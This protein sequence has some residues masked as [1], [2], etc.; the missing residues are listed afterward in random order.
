HIEPKSR[1]GLLTEDNTQALCRKCNGKKGSGTMADL[2][3]KLEESS[4]E[5][6]PDFWLMAQNLTKA[7][8]YSIPDKAAA[9]RRRKAE[10][11]KAL[12]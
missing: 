11:Q 9:T 3:A 5:W 6:H 10:K 7:K 2:W 12:R 1:G 4:N 8:S